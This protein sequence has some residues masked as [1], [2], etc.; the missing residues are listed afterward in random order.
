MSSDWN[1]LCSEMT[2]TR[3]SDMANIDLDWD[4][5]GIIQAEES[6]KGMLDVISQ[7]TQA[8]SGTFWCWDGRVSLT[9]LVSVP[10][11]MADS[12]THSPTLGDRSL[13]KT[14][15][16]GTTDKGPRPRMDCGLARPEGN[17]PMQDP[18]RHGY[19]WLLASNH[20]I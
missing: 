8:D 9:T 14:V 4:V 18:W 13:Q 10:D 16:K 20:K 19:T 5:E 12:T 2:D 15:W 7:K 17:I 1:R 11:R 6:V 3:D